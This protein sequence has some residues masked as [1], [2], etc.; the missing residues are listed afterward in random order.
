M[1]RQ[2]FVIGITNW[3][4]LASPSSGRIIFCATYSKRGRHEIRI[5]TCD[6]SLCLGDDVADQIRPRLPRHAGLFDVAEP[7]VLTYIDATAQHRAELHST[8]PLQRG[9]FAIILLAQ[10]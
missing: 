1:P 2:G 7:D 4:I 5:L 6:A 10:S 8:N 9:Q 3:T